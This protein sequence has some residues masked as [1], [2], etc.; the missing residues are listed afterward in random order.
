MFTVFSFYSELPNEVFEYVEEY[1][2]RSSLYNPY[3]EGSAIL[4]FAL[5]TH[6]E[7]SNVHK[8]RGQQ[9]GNERKEESRSWKRP[10]CILTKTCVNS[11]RSKGGTKD[12]DHTI[13]EWDITLQ[14]LQ[15]VYDQARFE[16]N[17]Q[18]KKK[19]WFIQKKFCFRMKF[20]RRIP[21]L[22]GQ[23]GTQLLLTYSEVFVH[24]WWHP[25]FNLMPFVL[26]L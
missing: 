9:L 17:L 16:R 11:Y 14:E 20:K 12:F 18:W 6:E 3:R 26:C 15:V 5:F 7:K 19:Y 10:D 21:W 1:I 22:Y 24:T 2:S 4:K 13:P 25:S 8:V 23:N